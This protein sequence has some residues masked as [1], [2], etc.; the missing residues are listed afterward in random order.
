MSYV[1]Q[2]DWLAEICGFD[3]FTFWINSDSIGFIDIFSTGYIGL[4]SRFFIGRES[5]TFVL[6]GDSRYEW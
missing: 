1:F 6:I 5:C 4:I 3:V 2:S